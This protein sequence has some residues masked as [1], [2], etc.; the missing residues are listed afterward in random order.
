MT[1]VHDPPSPRTRPAEIGEETLIPLGE[2][3]SDSISP[4][5]EDALEPS[6][7]QMHMNLTWDETGTQKPPRGDESESKSESNDSPAAPTDQK[8]FRLFHLNKRG[9]DDDEET[10]WWFASTAIPLLAATIAPLANV[11]SISALVT[12]W[13]MDLDDGNGGFLPELNGIPFKDPRW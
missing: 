8:K 6:G 4:I 13:R 3:D 1:T 2:P 9:Y 5:R 7:E 11:L 12:D 10:D